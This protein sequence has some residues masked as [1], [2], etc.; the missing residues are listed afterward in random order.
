LRNAGALPGQQ[1]KSFLREL[2]QPTDG[3]GY[4]QK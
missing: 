2:D 4:L 1:L 3:R